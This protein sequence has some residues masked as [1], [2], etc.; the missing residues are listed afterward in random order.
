MIV[1]HVFPQRLVRAGFVLQSK[2]KKTIQDKD[3]GETVDRSI[4]AGVEGLSG[5]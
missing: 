1:G 2:N 3:Y 5:K 4:I